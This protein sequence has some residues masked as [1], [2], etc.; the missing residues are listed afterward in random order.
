MSIDT[1]DLIHRF[2]FNAENRI[3]KMVQEIMYYPVFKGAG[4]FG[5]WRGERG[6]GL[7]LGEPEN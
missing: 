1:E 5:E 2:L 4:T 6:R 3:G 7:C